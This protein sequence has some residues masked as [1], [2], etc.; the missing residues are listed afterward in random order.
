MCR[1]V[2]EENFERE[3]ALLMEVEALLFVADIIFE[4]CLIVRSLKLLYET[5]FVH[6]RPHLQLL[7]FVST[8]L[9]SYRLLGGYSDLESII[10]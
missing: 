1:E 7:C 10:S 4:E 8:P 2:Y 5:S 3:R 6:C 9:C